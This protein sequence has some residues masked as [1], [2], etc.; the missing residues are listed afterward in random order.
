M[1]VRIMKLMKQLMSVA[2]AVTMT[3][4]MSAG[5]MAA[6][7]E[8][9]SAPSGDTIK[10]GLMIAKNGQSLSSDEWEVLAGIFEDVINNKHEDLSLPFAA[11]EGLPNL[12]GAKVE[13]VTGEQIDTQT[14]V[15][16]AERLI[17]EEGVVGLFGH[18]TSNTTAAAMVAAEKYS[19]PLLSEGTSMSLL[20]AGYDYWLRSFGGDDFYVESSMEFIDSVKEASGDISTIALCSENSDFGTGI[21]TLEKAAA[22]EHGYE[23]IENVFYDSTDRDVSSKVRLLKDAGADVVMMS[24]YATDALAFME[25]FKAQDYFPKMLLGQRG[26]FMSSGFAKTLGKDADTVL[27]TA[28]WAG[29]MDNDASKQIAALFEEKTGSALIGDVLVDVWNGVLLAAAINQA[30]TTDSAAVRAAFAEGLDLDPALDPMALD[31][32]T[33]GETGENSNH[34]CVI[35]QYSDGALNTVYPED[36]AVAELSYPS[37][38]WSER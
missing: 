1:E 12:G 34:A 32:Y 10:L 7:T 29:T 30:G 37:V 15:Q 27:T 4:G 2:L 18:F 25:E 21:A 14:A 19:V 20:D 8:A 16:E 33:Y 31:G 23:V 13:F 3:A 24:S 38:S 22:E 26:G 17:Q 35:V 9:D 28:R 6:E 11:D 36:K 5:V